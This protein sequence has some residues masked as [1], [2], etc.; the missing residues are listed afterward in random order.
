VPKPIKLQE[1]HR[2]MVPLDRP[3]SEDTGRLLAEWA[4][5]GVAAD[6][7]A[8]RIVAK[9]LEYAATA[10]TTDTLTAAINTKRSS[11]TPAAFLT[12]LKGQERRLDEKLAAV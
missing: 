5:G 4:A 2:G 8:D 9:L 1:Q 6:A 10:G 7:D 12:W 3:L 11:A